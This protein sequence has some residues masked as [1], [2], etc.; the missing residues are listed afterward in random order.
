MTKFTKE[1][2]SYSG[3]SLTYNGEFIARFKHGSARASATHFKKFL[4]AN[5]TVF[6]YFDLTLGANGIS[7]LKAMESKGYVGYNASQEL[8]R[9]G[10]PVT[11]EGQRMY[12]EDMIYARRAAVQA[13]TSSEGK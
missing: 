1:G 4:M 6:E 7:P 8:K 2:F 10:Y 11:L 3:G 12:L 13:A 5:F 9:A